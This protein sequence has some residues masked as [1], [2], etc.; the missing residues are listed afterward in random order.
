MKKKKN[1]AID[2]LKDSAEFVLDIFTEKRAFGNRAIKKGTTI[3][4][5]V[6]AGL[7]IAAFSSGFISEK[8]MKC[9]YDATQ[10]IEAKVKSNDG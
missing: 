10:E 9:M 5:V 2:K 7:L 8:S 6:G 4:G 1:D 3:T